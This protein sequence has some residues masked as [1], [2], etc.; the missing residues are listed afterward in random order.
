[1]KPP[2]PKL[3]RGKT[4]QR[5]MYKAKH[6]QSLLQVLQCQEGEPTSIALG[7][8][9]K[10]SLSTALIKESL[11]K[12]WHFSRALRDGWEGSTRKRTKSRT[13]FLGD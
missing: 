7:F 4:I 12:R 13:F 3:G 1:M 8:K 6:R 11:A 10:G 2:Q 9:R 5:S